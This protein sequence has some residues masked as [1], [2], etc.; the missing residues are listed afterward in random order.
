VRRVLVASMSILLSLAGCGA[1]DPSDGPIAITAQ[2]ADAQYLEETKRWDLP[3]GWQWPETPRFPEVAEDGGPI[4]YG[5]D[6]GRVDATHYWYCAWAIVLVR[7]VDGPTRTAALHEVVKLPD[8][9]Y[10]QV[11]LMSTERKD[12]IL[13]AAELGDYGPMAN[14]VQLNCPEAG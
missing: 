5:L 6:M 11:G 2:E 8:T 3:A 10:Y 9:P 12:R 7:A 1:G 13:A 4:V 14:D